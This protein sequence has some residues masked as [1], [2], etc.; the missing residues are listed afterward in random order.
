[1]YENPNGAGAAFLFDDLL[2][3]VQRGLALV[4]VCRVDI[5]KDGLFSGSRDLLPDAF[6]IG[7]GGSAIQMH[8]E[9]VHSSTG[10]F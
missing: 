6:H 2:H 5:E 9:N 3:F 1:V 10:Q 8:A 7:H 4:V